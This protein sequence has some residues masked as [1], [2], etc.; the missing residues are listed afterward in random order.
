MSVKAIIEVQ[1][2]NFCFSKKQEILK[3]VTLSVSEGSIYGFL[4][5][6]GAGKT[7]TIRAILGLL[8][9][10]PNTIKIF[11]LPFNSNRIQIL[12]KIGAFVEDPALY[13]HLS[14]YNNLLIAARIRGINKNRID[15]VIK[16]VNMTTDAHRPAKQ[17]STG[18]KQRISL[19]MAMLSNPELIIL[20]EPTNGLDPKGII[21]IREIIQHLNKEEGKT[22]F[23][24]SHL[25]AEIEKVCTHVGV[26][27]RGN[28]LFDGS[29]ENLRNIQSS[30][31]QVIIRTNS[32][33]LAAEELSDLQDI[34]I[35]DNNRISCPFSSDKNVANIIKR[36]ATNGIEIYQIETDRD[37]LEELFLNLTK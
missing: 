22:I 1:N 11:G 23:L 37:N 8:R 36:L 20:D 19:A 15:H 6:N 7:T 31:I 28:I 32:S 14:G 29:I 30:A 21:E 2:L 12:S 24:S 33:K 27:K 5:P 35:I 10:T 17:Y 18:M 16:Q 34:K 13:S 25:L 4:G 26:I 9:V 3:D